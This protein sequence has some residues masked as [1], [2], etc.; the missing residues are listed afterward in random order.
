MNMKVYNWFVDYMKAFTRME[1][2]A[3]GSYA[4]V[5]DCRKTDKADEDNIYNIMQ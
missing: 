5:W 3:V 4:V 1:Q 2:C